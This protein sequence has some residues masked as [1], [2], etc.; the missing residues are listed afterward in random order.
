MVDAGAV[1]LREALD[2]QTA[3]FGPAGD[4]DRAGVDARAVVDLHH[5]GPLVAMQTDGR[6]TDH[7]LRAEL[8]RLREGTRGELL[9]GDA[10][11]EAEVVLDPHAGSRL[12][13]G[14]AGLDEQHI[15]P[16]RGSVD[17]D[18]QAGG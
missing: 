8:L 9:P 12:A 10:G 7:R 16:F 1:E 14:S 2:G 18:T 13:P 15:E 3:V 4:D 11:G 17:R 6:A 5:I